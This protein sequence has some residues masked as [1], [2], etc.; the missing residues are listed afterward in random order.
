M[1]RTPIKSSLKSQFQ[2]GRTCMLLLLVSAMSSAVAADIKVNSLPALQSAISNANAGDVI[3]LADGVYTSTEAITIDRQGTAAKPITI[4]AQSILGAE[5][6]GTQG[7]I[8]NSPAKH[9]IIK[10]FK[11]THASSSA[12]L[13]AGSSFIRLTQNLY[14]TTG[15][16]DYLLINGSDQEVDHCTFQNKNSLG[17]FIIVRGT[18]SQIAERLHIHHNYF[19]KQAQQTG[20]G[21]E[22]IQFGLSGFSLSNTN[23]IVE[24]NLF[25]ECAGENE[26]LSVKASQLTVRYN[27]IRNCPAQFTLRHGNRCEVYGNYFLNTPGLRIFGDDHKIYGNYFEACSVAIN[28]GNGGA[29]VADG[30]PLTS[31]D[32]PDRNFVVYNTLVN[33]ITNYVQGNRKNGLGSV[34]TTFANNIIQGGGPAASITGPY[35]NGVWSNNIIYQTNGIGDMPA[36]SFNETN[37]QL[38]RDASGTFHLKKGSAA[39]DAGTGSFVFAVSDMDGQPRKGPFDI[40]ADEVSNATIKAQLLAPSMVGPDAK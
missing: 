26:L 33:N 2:K 27:T 23:S 3:T 25:E 5:I 22:T 29:E 10:G 7:F 14:Q 16:G 40:G 18:G 9:I 36:S 12:A 24:Y 8:V 30:A 19:Y 4:Q 38:V 31:H 21:N 20:N 37:P 34:A 6:S 32:R 35:T 1:K 28:M 15:N 39:I 11:F 17:K 13:N